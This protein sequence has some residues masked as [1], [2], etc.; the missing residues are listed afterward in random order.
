LVPEQLVLFQSLLHYLG[1]DSQFFFEFS[2]GLI[3]Q[4]EFLL[5]YVV[6]CFGFLEFVCQIIKLLLEAVDLSS[7]FISQQEIRMD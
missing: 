2:N 3:R 4:L 1:L 6:A 7:K 5:C